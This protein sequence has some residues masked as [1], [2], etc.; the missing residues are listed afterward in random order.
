MFTAVFEVRQTVDINRKYVNELEILQAVG[1]L[2]KLESESWEFHKHQ[3]KQ[4]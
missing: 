3:H 2:Y 4:A 1:V